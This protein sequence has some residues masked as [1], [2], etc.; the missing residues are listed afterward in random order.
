[1]NEKIDK[2]QKKLKRYLDENRY[3][4]TIGVMYT[5]GALAMCHGENVEHAM[6]A[7]LLHDCAKCIP[8]DKKIRICRKNNIPIK[9]V[10]LSNP[11]LL[12][13]KI[14]AYF[15]ETKYHIKEE[16]V[17][18]AIKYHTTGRPDMSGIEK[19]VYIA[20]CIEPNRRPL[21]NTGI[22]RKLAFEDLDRCICRL[23]EDSLTYLRSRNI[24]IDPQT[25]ETYNFY[26]NKMES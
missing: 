21:P 24:P 5:S 7:G 8:S 22:V 13:A 2:I 25:E 17:L 18:N 20:D 11:G 26:K 12:H 23:L 19:I 10:E 15:A 4:H 16:S 9:D 1:M 3:Q 14:G 6:L